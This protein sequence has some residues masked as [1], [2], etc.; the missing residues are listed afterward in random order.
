MADSRCCCFLFFVSCFLQKRRYSDA[1]SCE[2]PPGGH[3][4]RHR[5][6]TLSGLVGRSAG[7]WRSAS[8]PQS[9][10]SP[11]VMHG[12]RVRRVVSARYVHAAATDSSKGNSFTLSNLLFTQS[13]AWFPRISDPVYRGTPPFKRLWGTVI[14]MHTN[15]DHA[16]PSRSWYGTTPTRDPLQP[17]YTA[18]VSLFMICVINRVANSFSHR[19]AP[20][21]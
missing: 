21:K 3:G 4:D 12:G 13:F 11:I 7:R 2:S 17:Q 6:S 10:H 1:K 14:D 18:V 8:A 19:I 20:L 15:L 5:R 9:G 16:C